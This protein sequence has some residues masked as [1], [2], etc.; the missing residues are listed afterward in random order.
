MSMTNSASNSGYDDLS[1]SL[2]HEMGTG[3]GPRSMIEPAAW[4]TSCFEYGIEDRVEQMIGKRFV[5]CKGFNGADKTSKITLSNCYQFQTGN[6]LKMWDVENDPMNMVNLFFFMM[7][8]H[9]K[10]AME[11]YGLEDVPLFNSRAYAK[12]L[13]VRIFFESFVHTNSIVCFLSNHILLCIQER[14]KA[15]LTCEAGL[16]RNNKFGVN[17]FNGI[18]RSLALKCDFANKDTYTLRSARR[19]MLTKMKTALNR[20]EISAASVLNSG[21]HK[22]IDV[23]VLYQAEDDTDH[24][25]RNECI[26]Y[27]P[28]KRGSANDSG[29]GFTRPV[30][31]QRTS[32]GAAPTGTETVPQASVAVVPQGVVAAT[33]QASV[34]M[35]PPS[36]TVPQVASTPTSNF[37]SMMPMLQMMMMQQMM[38]MMGGN[39]QP[40]A[41]QVPQ[42]MAAQIQQPMAA[43]VPQPMAAAAAQQPT[44]ATVQDDGTAPVQNGTDDTSAEDA[45]SIVYPTQQF[46]D[47]V[48]D[49]GNGEDDDFYN[50]NDI[51]MGDDRAVDVEDGSDNE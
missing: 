42:P 16:E 24:L 28:N 20:S 34:P 22:S 19:L 17:R 49:N 13:K 38:Q 45:Y 30:Q 11:F 8:M 44:M 12:D 14:R 41:A 1:E 4:T 10:P 31:K 47:L 25:A 32:V 36:A 9:L 18:I 29:L 40:M 43:Q 37:D 26:H 50:E 35:M 6:Y 46:E 7:D 51:D 3:F 48:D 27:N 33:P 39:Q 2:L 23:S 15:G 21:R 5:R